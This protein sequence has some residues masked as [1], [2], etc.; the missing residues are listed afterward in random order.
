MN[1]CQIA[2][3]LLHTQPL[4]QAGNL[5][6]Y[7]PHKESIYI[8]CSYVHKLINIANGAV[9]ADKG[10]AD[11]RHKW[12]DVTDEYCLIKRESNYI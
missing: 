8:Y 2:A 4:L 12:Y 7:G 9:Y 6:T 5:Y 3:G 1:I 10:F 11:N